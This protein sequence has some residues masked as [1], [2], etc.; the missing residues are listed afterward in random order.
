M[1]KVTLLS[2]ATATLLAS[3][4]TST[5][6]LVE[7]NQEVGTLGISASFGI[8]V[9][10]QN[11]F[12]TKDINAFTPD[13]TTY[14]Y[15]VLNETGTAV[16]TNLPSTTPSAT[17]AL[18]VWGPQA[19]MDLFPGSYQVFVSN[20]AFGYACTPAT[21]TPTK[22]TDF[23]GVI[24]ASTNST[25]FE[26]TAGNNTNAPIATEWKM[27]SSVIDVVAHDAVSETF[28]STLDSY[29]IRIY[30]ATNSLVVWDKTTDGALTV[31]ATNHQAYFA[32]ST[33]SVE[34]IYKATSASTP[35]TV[36]KAEAIVIAEGTELAVR[37]KAYNGT[38]TLDVTMPDGT[39]I[40]G[41]D[42][43]FN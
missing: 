40:P 19:P 21:H 43:D 16:V 9:E 37:F 2:L 15:N 8:S 32:P 28:F 6:N 30:D 7:E 3:C 39:T 10:E 1:K 41:T 42:V 29:S 13:A 33:Y 34:L 26:V 14:S 11:G 23:A 17:L 31:T 25:A 18:T 12:S 5:E 24:Y 27:L 22:G 36:S 20:K 4:A 38:I 35:V